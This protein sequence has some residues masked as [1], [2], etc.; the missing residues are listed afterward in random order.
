MPHNLFAQ[1]VNFEDISAVNNYRSR[2]DRI[3]A[4]SSF[5]GLAL[6]MKEK[7]VRVYCAEKRRTQQLQTVAKLFGRFVQF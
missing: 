2:F 6:T 3:I 5:P 7:Q 1:G 4:R